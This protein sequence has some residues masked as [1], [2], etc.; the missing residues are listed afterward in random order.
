MSHSRVS[1][2]FCFR[3]HINK[4]QRWGGLAPDRLNALLNRWI[5]LWPWHHP[6][7]CIK[8]TQPGCWAA[9]W[10]W[11]TCSRYLCWSPLIMCC[12][13][14]VMAQVTGTTEFQG[15]DS[16]S[17]FV[18]NEQVSQCASLHVE[19]HRHGYT[20]CI[21][22]SINSENT[23]NESIRGN[24]KV[25]PQCLNYITP[26]IIFVTAARSFYFGEVLCFRP[27]VYCTASLFGSVIKTGLLTCAV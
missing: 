7:A 27:S 22:A 6:S 2:T 4:C 23:W 21:Y 25:A 26:Q 10:F 1:A 24:Y 15:Q 12:L 18:S 11:R 17:N 9:A 19:W 5:D 20:R 14:R 16:P 8:T 13:Q 3:P